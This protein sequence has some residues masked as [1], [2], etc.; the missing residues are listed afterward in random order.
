MSQNNQN[1]YVINASVGEVLS[2]Y[3][4]FIVVTIAYAIAFVIVYFGIP[5]LMYLW[6]GY[7]I[8]SNTAIGYYMEFAVPLMM[9]TPLLLIAIGLIW[10][11]ASELTDP[12]MNAVRQ[13]A[14]QKLIDDNR[15]KDKIEVIAENYLNKHLERY[16]FIKV[17]KPGLRGRVE[18]LFKKGQYGEGVV[19]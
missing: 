12:V 4:M 14:I 6:W 19:M 11:V 2:K 7:N 9:M 18:V 15:Y 3:R 16:G 5:H 1:K 8:G 13:R 17:V 10:H